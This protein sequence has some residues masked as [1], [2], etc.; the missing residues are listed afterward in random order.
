MKIP[1]SDTETAFS[2]K[3]NT[4]LYQDYLLFKMIG[5]PTLVSVGSK[6]IQ[7]LNKTPLPYQLILK[8][9]LFDH[10]CGGETA[11]DCM[12]LVR[13]LSHYQIGTILDYSVEAAQ[14]ESVFDAT[15]K[16]I[17]STLTFASQTPFI[18]FSV[19]KITGLAR[20]ALLKKLHEKEIL[21]DPEQKEWNRVIQRVRTIIQKASVLKIRI[22]IDAEESWI[23]DPIDELVETL[24]AEFNQREPI[25]F[26]TL[27][28]YRADRLNYLH[29]LL[30]KS[31]TRQFQLGIKLVRGAYMEKE[32][33]RAEKKGYPSPIHPTKTQTDE[34]YDKALQ[35]CIDHISQ[36][37]LFLGTHNEHSC[38]LAVDKMLEKGLTPEN[39]R[40][41]FSQ[42]FGMSDNLTFN[43]AKRGFQTAKYVPY[44]PV[45]ELAPYLIRRAQENTAISGQTSRELELIKK[46][47]TRRRVPLALGLNWLKK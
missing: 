6:V 26:H 35:L 37:S 15:E 19:F 5:S 38:Q 47:L 23:Q 30:Q 28:M 24:M 44:G 43:L 17:T 45:R 39:P 12:D 27:Q 18:P 13:K 41:F 14:Q 29:S 21:S 42:L 11:K 25:V 31:Q 22:L 3:S 8:A 32:R 20:F 36:A 34:A 4:E 16:E 1:F 9:G 7:T 10:F 33:K 2:L 46:E 40:I